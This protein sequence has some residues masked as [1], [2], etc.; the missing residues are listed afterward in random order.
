M[1]LMISE[2]LKLDLSLFPFLDKNCSLLKNSLALKKNYIELPDKK[3]IRNRNCF[4]VL[5]F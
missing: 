3:R 1:G 2:S 4:T 5:D